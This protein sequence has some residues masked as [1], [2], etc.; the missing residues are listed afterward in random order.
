MA[1]VL[2][3]EDIGMQATLIERYLRGVHD[4]VDVV[5]TAED[6]VDRVRETDPD[7]VVMDLNLREGTGIEA[8]EAIKRLDRGVGVVISTVAA[9][10]EVRERALDAGADAYLVKPYEQGDLLEAVKSAA[11]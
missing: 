11:A 2:I 10:A 3:A 1:N 5:A 8:T 7:V 6:A 9:D 4:V